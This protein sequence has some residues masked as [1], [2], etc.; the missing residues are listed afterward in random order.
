MIPMQDLHIGRFRDGVLTVVTDRAGAFDQSQGV[1]R[2]PIELPRIVLAS[3]IPQCIDS[4][5]AKLVRVL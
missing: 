2:Q 1:S 4:S 5:A 3:S